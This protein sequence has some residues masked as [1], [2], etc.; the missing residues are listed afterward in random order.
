MALYVRQCNHQGALQLQL[1]KFRRQTCSPL[2]ASVFL[3]SVHEVQRQQ[4][5][6]LSVT[7]LPIEWKGAFSPVAE[8]F[9]RRKMTESRNRIDREHHYQLGT[10]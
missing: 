4:L 10:R 8:A 9:A 6:C 5:S 7:D 2:K 3:V 1:R